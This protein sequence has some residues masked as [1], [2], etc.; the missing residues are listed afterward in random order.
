MSMN[1]SI[2]ICWLWIAIPEHFSQCFFPRVFFCSFSLLC[3]VFLPSSWLSSTDNVIWEVDK[4]HTF[5]LANVV[6][7]F[8]HSIGKNIREINIFGHFQL[9]YLPWEKLFR[10]FL[11]LSFS[12][13][14]ILLFHMCLYHNSQKYSMYLCSHF[15]TISMW[16]SLSICIFNSAV[17][18][19]L[20][21]SPSLSLSFPYEPEM[22]R[23]YYSLVLERK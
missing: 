21:F 2:F 22:P 15:W 8:V 14:V 7:V 10:F 19:S 5:F 9:I 16:F 1:G 23:L 11:S 20:S 18:S 4:C 12:I 13:S 3:D 17:I 6:V